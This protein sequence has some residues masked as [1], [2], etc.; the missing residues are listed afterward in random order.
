[1]TQKNCANNPPPATP[2]INKRYTKR[3]TSQILCTA[4]SVRAN[5]RSASVNS[6]FLYDFIRSDLAC[7]SVDGYADEARAPVFVRIALGV[8][9]R[10]GVVCGAN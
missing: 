10:H 4:E 3:Y 2:P 6:A 7:F 9:L 5:D 1:M 8:Y